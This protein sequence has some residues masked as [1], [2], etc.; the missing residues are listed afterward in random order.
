MQSGL[1]PDKLVLLDE[2]CGKTNMPRPRG[3]TPRG[4][5]LLCHTPH[6]HWK[7]TTT[8]AGLRLS[9]LTAPLVIEGAVNGAV[10][11]NCVRQHRS[12]TRGACGILIMDNL[13]CHKVAGVREAVEA[14]AHTWCLYLPTAR[15]SI[16]SS[17]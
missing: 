15:I 6:G 12:P 7:T 4:E 2:T 14:R 5:R 9:G 3:R 1:D 17:W 11:V 16:R 13:F 10:F 8:L